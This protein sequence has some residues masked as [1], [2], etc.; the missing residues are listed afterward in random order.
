MPEGYPIKLVRDRVASIDTSQGLAYRPVADRDE[1]VLRL[2]AKLVEEVGEYLIDPS[3][4]ELADILQVVEDLALVDVP[5]APG[6]HRLSLAMLRFRQYKKHN[7]R[8]GFTEGV[9]METIER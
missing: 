1:H 8:G 9:V 7:E 4:D 2:R 5:E 3:L 6:D